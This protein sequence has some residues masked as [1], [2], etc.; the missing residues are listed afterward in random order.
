MTFKEGGSR[1][2][3]RLL[4]LYI[5]GGNCW[6]FQQS[7]LE[8]YG[9]NSRESWDVR[10]MNQCGGGMFTALEYKLFLTAG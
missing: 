1:T 10:R 3:S 6:Y 8:R 4:E 9:W 2:S 7:A 5:E